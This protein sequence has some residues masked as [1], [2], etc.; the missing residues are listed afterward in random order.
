[1]AYDDH[2]GMRTVMEEEGLVGEVPNATEDWIEQRILHV[3]KIY[4]KLSM[5]M[6]QVGV[7]TSLAPKVWK[8]ILLKMVENEVLNMKQVSAMTPDGRTQT[9]TVISVSAGVSA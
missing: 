3:L 2:P 6:L 5:S 1:M 8:P 9:Y 4:P 7:G